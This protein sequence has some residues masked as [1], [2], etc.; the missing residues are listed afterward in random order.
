MKKHIC[1]IMLFNILIIAFLCISTEAATLKLNKTKLGLQYG[2]SYVL[3]ANQTVTWSSSNKKIVT[4][5]SSGKIKAV[6]SGVAKVT[7]KNKKGKTKTCRVTVQNYVIRKTGNNEY[8]NK[9]TVYRN[10][11]SSKTYTIYNQKGYDNTWVKNRGCSACA[12]ATV[13]SAY[14]QTQSPMDIHYG[15]SN[16]P[17][18]ERYALAKLGKDVKIN[19]KSLTIYSLTQMLHNTGIKCHAVYKYSN[20]SAIKEIT[21]NLKSGRPVIIIAHNKTVNGN[22]LATYIHFLVV[23]GIDS[24]GKAIVLNPAGG[25]VNKSHFTGSFKLTVSQLVKRHM[26][27]CTGNNYKQFY[28]K[29]KKNAGGYIVIDE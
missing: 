11:G 19:N 20:S 10:N 28:Y 5:S 9:I 15:T 12:I 3:K 26:F 22:R 21:A 8:P 17:Y 16:R 6:G 2:K 29:H 4:V 14:G 1:G 7:A 24:D 23:V 18:S 13:A 27:S 25:T